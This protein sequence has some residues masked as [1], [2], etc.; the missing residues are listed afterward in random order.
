MEVE[1]TARKIQNFYIVNFSVCC[2]C[3]AAAAAAAA[4]FV[5]VKHKKFN[6]ICVGS[7]S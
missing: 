4:Q 6:V 1:R 5:R 2:E 3:G 7:N